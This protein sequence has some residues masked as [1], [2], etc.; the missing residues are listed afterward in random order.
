M[1]NTLNR[2][3]NSEMH[4]LNLQIFVIRYFESIGVFILFFFFFLLFCAGRFRFIFDP[5]VMPALMK[6]F[7]LSGRR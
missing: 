4:I 3:P 1:S 5:P 6:M 7:S 2:V